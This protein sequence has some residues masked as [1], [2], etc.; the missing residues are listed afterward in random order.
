MTTTTAAKGHH[1]GWDIYKEQGVP[2]LAMPQRPYWFAV[3]GDRRIVNDTKAGLIATIDAP[4]A[5]ADHIARIAA[6]LSA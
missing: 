1:A 5:D 2:G 6:M 4:Q 3:K